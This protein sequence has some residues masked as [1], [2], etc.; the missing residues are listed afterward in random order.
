MLMLGVNKN[1]LKELP[2]GR[3]LAGK[4][5]ESV[6]AYERRITFISVRAD[7][8]DARF[9]YFA[10]ELWLFREG[11]AELRFR[12]RIASSEFGKPVAVG[13]NVHTE[14]HA[15]L[16]PEITWLFFR[17]SFTFHFYPLIPRWRIFH[18]DI[19]E[20]ERTVF[21]FWLTEFRG[22]G[23]AAARYKHDA[24]QYPYYSRCL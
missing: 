5:V 20:D 16:H 21:N 4:E 17:L 11:K 2:L 18:V 14:K 3:S 23:G 13:R 19:A 9:V 12:V 8:V 24:Q 7:E 15:V 1:F 10:P 6:S 22:G